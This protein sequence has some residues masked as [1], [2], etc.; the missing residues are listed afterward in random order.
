M[1]KLFILLTSLLALS[2]CASA[3]SVTSPSEESSVLASDSL[4]GSVISSSENNSASFSIDS[5]VEASLEESSLPLVSSS[6]PS[7][8]VSSISVKSGSVK[9]SYNV[10]DSF[11]VKGGKLIVRYSDD[12]AKEVSMTLDMIQNVP[13]MSKPTSNY[14]VQ[15]MYQNKST[16]YQI[17]IKEV[18][19]D[20]YMLNKSSLT[21][22][23]GEKFQ[24]KV[25]KNGSLYTGNI[26][27]AIST[28]LI[29]IDDNGVVIGVYPTSS[30][31]DCRAQAWSPYF[32][33]F[34]EISVIGRNSN[35]YRCMTTHSSSTP[36]VE[37]GNHVVYTVSKEETFNGT[38]KYR[39]AYRFSYD[40]LTEECFISVILN[41]YWVNS[42][43]Y[44]W[45]EVIAAY[46]R[47]Y[48]G[49]YENGAF[50]GIYGQIIYD[51]D[52]PRSYQANIVYNTEHFV[53]DSENYKIGVHSSKPYYT[54]MKDEFEE[55]GLVPI[56]SEE[57]DQVTTALVTCKTFADSEVFGSYNSKN[58]KDQIRLF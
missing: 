13:D 33:L 45:I 18:P 56:D 30:D 5:S 10:G 40:S 46:N 3:P 39:N 28:D 37:S 21:L 35:I 8:E 23:V 43:G 58:P 55:G 16:S 2:G 29:D 57:V 41:N 51:Q 4:V 49:E 20:V 32:S 17:S 14:T 47:F 42:E 24:L 50:Y 52:P 12:S 22:E 15:V 36:E 48:W 19:V 25:Y 27:W 44:Q 53:F 26:T 6:T 1:K 11:T 9:T 34:C 31:I 54:V 7:V 38:R